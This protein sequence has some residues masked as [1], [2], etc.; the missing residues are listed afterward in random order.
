M[1]R[2][3]RTALA[4]LTKYARAAISQV[5]RFRIPMRFVRVVLAT[6]GLSALV[7]TPAHGNPTAPSAAPSTDGPGVPCEVAAAVDP[8]PDTPITDVGGIELPVP[9][10]GIGAYIE[11]NYGE[12]GSEELIVTSTSE[13]EVTVYECGADS[14]PAVI[15]YRVVSP[16]PCQ[17]NAYSLTEWKWYSRFHWRFNANSTPANLTK[18]DAEQALKEGV[19][20]IPNA[21]NDCA[22]SLTT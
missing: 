18:A 15:D 13:G 1:K 4:A 3:K 7:V 16:P 9:P 17:D 10:A 8:P 19:Q 2:R 12:L 14:D 22:D 20:A 11:D 6:V 21:N 5:P